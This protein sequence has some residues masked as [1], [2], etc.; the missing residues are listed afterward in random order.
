MKPEGP[1]V[2]PFLLAFFTQALTALGKKAALTFVLVELVEDSPPFAP[3][4]IFF[5]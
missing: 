5:L 3:G 4:A 2:P 1:L